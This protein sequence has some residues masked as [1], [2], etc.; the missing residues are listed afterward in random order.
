MIKVLQQQL[1]QIHML[2]NDAL[3]ALVSGVM[4]STR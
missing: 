3:T 1:V 4:N 2:P